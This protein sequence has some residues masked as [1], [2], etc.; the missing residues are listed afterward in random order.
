M[1]NLEQ[2][3]TQISSPIFD[4]QWSIT[5]ERRRCGSWDANTLPV[6]VA[7]PDQTLTLA[8]IPLLFPMMMEA[9]TVRVRTNVWK[10]NT[11]IVNIAIYTHGYL[12]KPIGIK[13]ADI[14]DLDGI[15]LEIEMEVIKCRLNDSGVNLDKQQWSRYGIGQ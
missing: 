7:V 11:S 3:E 15:E 5:L 2:A 1:T 10:I 6:A 8:V 14:M 4:N 13:I 9:I 12:P